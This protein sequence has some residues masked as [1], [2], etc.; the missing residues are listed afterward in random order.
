[1]PEKDIQLSPLEQMNRIL[2]EKEAVIDKK[3]EELKN[4]RQELDTFEG[5]LAQKVLE[6]QKE[7]EQI[8]KEKNDIEKR[9]KELENHEAQLQLSMS[10]V[11]EEKV[12]LEERSRADLEKALGSDGFGKAG[13]AADGFDLSVLGRSIGIEMPESGTGESEIKKSAGCA[14][15]CEKE[16]VP[17]SGT[18]QPEIPEIFLKLEKE[19]VKTYSKWTKLEMIPERYCVQNGDKEIR[20]FDTERKY[21]TPR[22]EIIVFRKNART[23]KRLMGNIAGIER[24]AP[25][26]SI[27]AEENQLV[28]MMQFTADTKPSM[29]LKK[30]NDFIKNHLV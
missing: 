25:D 24:V 18:I 1:M 17:K 8:K 22:V 13:K 2:S 20:F 6:V 9:W 28:C 16:S 4:Y 3:M 11:L 7:Q 5:K 21:G 15:G 30:C 26:W 23:D 10:K 12:Y 19:I 29:V 14:S 27:N